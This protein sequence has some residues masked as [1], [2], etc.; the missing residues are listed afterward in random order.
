MSY[1]WGITKHRLR[2]VMIGCSAV[3]LYTL[4][5][6]HPA[7]VDDTQDPQVESLAELASNAIPD[8]TSQAEFTYEVVLPNG[9]TLRDG[10]DGSI[11]FLDENGTVLGGIAPAWAVD[12]EGA[13]VPT[14][15]EIEGSSVIQ[16]VEI[17]NDTKFP[18]VADPWLGVK[19]YKKITVSTSSKG[20]TINATPSAWGLTWSDNLMWSAHRSEVKN[21]VGAKR[22]NSS[23][24][25]QLDCH[26]LG[27]PFGLPVYNLE[28]W[29]PNVNSVHSLV[30]Y[31][32][33][34]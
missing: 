19:L 20:W 12:A 1:F 17:S 8:A 15:Y 18:V 13:P 14:H 3:L 26:L 2:S 5:G 4:A 24:S 6:L 22:W 32:C 31:Q 27:A 11:N 10:D 9:S 21:A 34:P 7:I 25:N 33:N 28:S 29:R 23:I 16:V 30:K